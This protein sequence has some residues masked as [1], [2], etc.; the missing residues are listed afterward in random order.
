MARFLV[1]R[2]YRFID[3]DPIIDAVK[4]VVQD[5]HLNNN[6]VHEISGVASTTL[7]NWFE[8][9]TR[10]PQ[11]STVSAVTAALG[12]V[13]RDRLDKNGSLVVG[14][15]KARDLDWHDEIEKQADWMLKQGK[16]KS[17][18]KRKAK[19]NGKTSS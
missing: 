19:P 1:Y 15:A 13:R 2:S 17:Q 7:T 12:Y 16:K 6:R 9:G 10:R 18:R 5:E 11:N 3:K 4:T 8:G 14:F